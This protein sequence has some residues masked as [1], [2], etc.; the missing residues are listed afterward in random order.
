M[1]SILGM[2]SSCRL[3]CTA[4]A[5]QQVQNSSGKRIPASFMAGFYERGEMKSID[6]PQNM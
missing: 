4:G 6:K 3:S 5:R 2:V 1:G